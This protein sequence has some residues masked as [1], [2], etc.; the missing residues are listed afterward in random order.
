MERRTKQN[1]HKKTHMQQLGEF[2]V[3]DFAF[4]V[5]AEKQLDKVTAEVEGQHS[6]ECCVLDNV[7]KLICKESWD[8]V[9]STH[10]LLSVDR[11][12]LTE[13]QGTNL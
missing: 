9:Q 3:A 5:L 6:M 7:L 11:K 1:T 2:I 8:S 13:R 4:L 10:T 12:T